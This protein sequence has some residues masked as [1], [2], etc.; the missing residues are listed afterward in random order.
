MGTIHVPAAPPGG[1][2]EHYTLH[3][4]DEAIPKSEQTDPNENTATIP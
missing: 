2:S 4:Q 3:S 1:Q